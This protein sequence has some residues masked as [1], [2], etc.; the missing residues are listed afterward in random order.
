MKK[1]TD[2][3]KT[4]LVQKGY[5]VLQ[6]DRNTTTKYKENKQGQ[7]LTKLNPES[8]PIGKG[9]GVDPNAES[10][11]YHAE[12]YVAKKETNTIKIAPDYVVKHI[13]TRYLDRDKA[14]LAI[15]SL[16]KEYELCRKAGHL[17]VKPLH[18]IKDDIYLIMKRMPGETMAKLIEKNAHPIEKKLQNIYFCLLALK[19]E[20]VDKGMVHNDLKPENIMIDD[21]GAHFIDYGFAEIANVDN[22]IEHRPC[23]TPAWV[24]PEIF[25]FKTN[26]QIVSLSI[27]QSVDIY[28]LGK[29]IACYLGGKNQRL[30]YTI[31]EVGEFAQHPECLDHIEIPWLEPLLQQMLA[32]NAR[33]RP[34]I[35]DLIVQYEQLVKLNVPKLKL[36][37]PYVG[38]GQR[39]LKKMLSKLT[40]YQASPLYSKYALFSRSATFLKELERLS[41]IADEGDFFTHLEAYLTQINQP[42]VKLGV[43]E[44][45]LRQKIQILID[46]YHSH[47]N[48]VIS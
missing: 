35:H 26:L 28:P 17:G 8:V 46:E 41:N 6:S 32:L 19:Y 14:L 24:A 23:G 21:T 4:Q 11:V 9:C 2:K 18:V 40:C 25:N 12:L 20:V 39:D 48:F 22:M 43:V 10:R 37:N 36:F 42:K 15:E 30:G 44:I 27:A 34:N 29:I 3:L 47:L 16:Q 45:N 33:T 1:A 7:I 38:K 5:V 31:D 13:N